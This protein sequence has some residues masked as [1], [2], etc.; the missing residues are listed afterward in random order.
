M[1]IGPSDPP[2]MKMATVDEALRRAAE[3][4][5]EAGI[6]D[7]AWQA[8]RLLRHVSGWDRAAVVS[9]AGEP[10]PPE[11]VA[12]LEALVGERVRRR[13]LQH[14]T[15]TQAFWRHEFVVTPDVLIP[16]PETELLVET[17][18]ELLRGCPSPRIVDVGTGSG[19]IALSLAA[20]R[21]DARVFATD[22]SA[23]AL[24]VASENARR[25]GLADRVRFH[26]GDL[27]APLEEAQ[28]SLDLIVS[29]PPYVDP[30]DLPSLSPEVRDHEPRTALLARDPPY[31]VYRRLAAQA[32][33]R[34]R[35]GGFLAVE[36]GRGM[37][38]EVANALAAAGFETPAFRRDLQGID[39]V[40]TTRTPGAGPRS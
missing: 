38:A 17:A 25:L 32:F 11:A 5:A 6:E 10:L 16:R 31:G 12:R 7:A 9:R 22:A 28:G 27:L 1:G 37:A 34:L 15:G 35:G 26:H 39:R 2:E 29:N 18:L 8:E 3:R 40:V 21:P 36:V 13:P 14:L 23:A 33:P 30:A 4:L 24:E 20:D 19:C